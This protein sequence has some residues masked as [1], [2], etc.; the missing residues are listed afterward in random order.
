MK[1]EKIIHLSHN[2]KSPSKFCQNYDMIS[3]EANNLGRYHNGPRHRNS[4]DT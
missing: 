3:D 4:K 1:Y 2:T